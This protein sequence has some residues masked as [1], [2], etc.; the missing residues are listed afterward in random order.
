MI[1]IKRLPQP[2]IGEKLSAEKQ[3]LQEY[4]EHVEEILRKDSISS[5]FTSRFHYKPIHLLDK[6][7]S[8]QLRKQFNNKCAYCEGEISL[9]GGGFDYFRPIGGIKGEG[10][11]SYSFHYIWLCY[12]WSNLYLICENCNSYKR[13][14]FPV[15]SI[16]ATFNQSVQNEQPLFID[17]CNEYP[18][19]HIYINQFGRMLGKTKKGE[20]SIDLLNLNSEYLIKRRKERI[21]DL[22]NILEKLIKSYRENRNDN[23]ILNFA[24]YIEGLFGPTHQYLA[25]RKFYLAQWI[26]TE[27]S[28]QEQ[29]EF[30]NNNFISKTLNAIYGHFNTVRELQDKLK[31]FLDFD[32]NIGPINTDYRRRLIEY[33]EIHNIRGINFKHKFETKNKNGAWLMLL[34]ENGAGKTTILQAIALAIANDWNGLSIN[35]KTFVPSNEEGYI[36]VKITDYDYPIEVFFRNGNVEYNYNGH[37]IPAIA[38]GAVRLISKRS[39]KKT[40]INPMRNLFVSKL[41]DYFVDN[42]K[43]L[44][45]KDKLG[46]SIATVILDVLP[47]NEDDTVDLVFKRNEVY[48]I[49][50]SKEIPL[51][52]LSSGYQNVIAITADIMRSI[53]EVEVDGV[54]HLAEG[55]VL[56]DEIDAHLHPTWKMRIVGSLRKAFPYMQFIVT[57]HDPLCL[58]GMKTH[59]IAVMREDKGNIKVQSDLPDPNSLRIDQI[60]TSDLFGMNSTIDV[61]HDELITKYESL[62]TAPLEL[63]KREFNQI[64]EQLNELNYLGATNRERLLYRVIDKYIASRK[65]KN[66]SY[67][68]MDDETQEEL[69]KLWNTFKEDEK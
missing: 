64:E 60:L 55:V 30:L 11:N 9:N 6:L 59:E 54:G 43:K 67:H 31:P 13:N 2:A 19:D 25:A 7:W 38:Y 26:M 49:R 28:P 24:G 56:I 22:R 62:L 50:D 20:N 29:I 40:N 52:Q 51:S 35:A 15:E 65:I 16:R 46:K 3:R 57:S 23:S 44:L 47:F 5:Y 69:I 1:F 37:L 61:K 14:F 68:K 10:E 32:S 27:L 18:E 58:R 36:K 4:V 66:E 39:S 48:L 42:P 53:Y 17:P 41:N 21:D 8:Q 33:I 34:G 12:E 63:D 45:K